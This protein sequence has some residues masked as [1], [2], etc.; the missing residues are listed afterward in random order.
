M[1]GRLPAGVTPVLRAGRHGRGLGFQYA[2]I[3]ET[4]NHDLA[5]LRSLQ[6]WTLKYAVESVPGVSQVA[7]VGGFVKQYQITIDPNRMHTYNLSIMKIM[8]AVRRSN[9][10]VEGRVIEWSGREYMVR[11]RGY[12]KDKRDIEKIAVGTDARARRSCSAT[13][14]QS[15]LGRRF[16]AAWPT[17]TARGGRR[18]HRRGSLRRERARCHR[19]REGK[20]QGNYAPLPEGVKIVTVYD[21]SELIHR[22]VE[23]LRDEIIKLGLA[24]SVVCVVFSSTS[25]APSS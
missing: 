12:I 8:E 5:Q 24:V 20:D 19:A 21:R 13:W 23:T 14:P 22:S 3:D 15:S 2:V 18:R 16:G 1:T 17:S 6:D 4:G 10:D 9:R 7:S 25:R 11:G